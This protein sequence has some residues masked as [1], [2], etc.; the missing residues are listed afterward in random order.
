MGWSD[1]YSE[2][3]SVYR[4]R[5]ELREFRDG[6]DG[7]GRA[8]ETQTR[9]V[10]QAFRLQLDGLGR[11]LETTAWN[12]LGLPAIVLEAGML[13]AMGYV[14]DLNTMAWTFVSMIM[15]V[16][17]VLAFQLLIDRHDRRLRKLLGIP[18]PGSAHGDESNVR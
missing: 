8:L 12:Y 5:Q 7:L 2:I 18:H 10:L 1:R 14:D 11:T 9:L 4:R 17:V 6:L 15:F 3:W 16:V 13:L